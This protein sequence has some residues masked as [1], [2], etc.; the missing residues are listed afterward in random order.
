MN[1]FYLRLKATKTKI[2]VILPPSLRHTIRIKG[3]F[4]NGSCIR[5]DESAKNLGVVIDDELTF[6][7]HVGKVVTSCNITIRKLSKIKEFLTYEQLRTAV[8]AYIFSLLDYCNSLFYGIQED[9][10]DKLQS[11]QNCAARLVKGKNKFKGSTAE[12]IR[13]CHWLRVRERIIF[14]IC[15]LVHKCLYGSAPACLK[16]KLKYSGSDRTMKLVQPTHEGTYGGRCF[17]RVGP[18]L[19]N[20]LPLKIRAEKELL[21][22]KKSSKTFLFDGFYEYQ[23]KIKAK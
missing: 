21:E 20:L 1:C 13:K 18:K 17:A 16:E 22:F 3:T 5:F 8:S 4:I 9:L 10:L 14:K 19:W 12:F 23:Q 15:L 11:V 6:R 7:E 2:L